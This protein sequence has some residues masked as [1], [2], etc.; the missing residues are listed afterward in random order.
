MS[1]H[2]VTSGTLPME[3]RNI[4]CYFKNMLSLR[5][6][7][8]LMIKFSRDFRTLLTGLRNGVVLDRSDW[9]LSCPGIN[10]SLSSPYQTRPSTWPIIQLHIFY[11]VMFKDQSLVL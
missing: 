5:T 8:I 2:C 6:L 1:L 9:E 10:S 11:R 3:W 7:L 4:E